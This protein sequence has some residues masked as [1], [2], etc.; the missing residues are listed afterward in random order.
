[1]QLA[2]QGGVAEGKPAIAPGRAFRLEAVRRIAMHV[3]AGQSGVAAK[4]RAQGTGRRVTRPASCHR[5]RRATPRDKKLKAKAFGRGSGRPGSRWRGEEMS[6]RFEDHPGFQRRRGCG[7]PPAAR[8]W[9]PRGMLALAVAG[10]AARDSASPLRRALGGGTGSWPPPGVAVT[11]DLWDVAPAFWSPLGPC[12]ATLGTAAGGGPRRL[13]ASAGTIPPVA[14]G[15]SHSP[16]GLRRR[17]R[18]GS[19]VLLRCMSA[20][21][22]I[23][24]SRL[25]RGFIVGRA[26]SDSGRAA[27]RH[28]LHVSRLEERVEDIPAGLGAAEELSRE[29]AQVISHPCALGRRPP[30]T[31]SQAAN[32]TFACHFVGRPS[33]E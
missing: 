8:R 27:S 16:G 18:A 33:L 1:M 12:G 25:D 26:S 20:A 23:G 32:V 4:G 17:G 6:V 29:I 7:R 9:A 10:S 30:R 22:A 2:Q 14:D 11:G 31:R 5:T 19:G 13:R 21:L 24:G 15:G 3:G 28:P